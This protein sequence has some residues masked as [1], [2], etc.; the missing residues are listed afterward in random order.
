VCPPPLADHT[1]SSGEVKIQLRQVGAGQTQQEF[2]FL[3]PQSVR[4]PWLG[5][6]LVGSSDLQLKLRRMELG[7][8]ERQRQREHEQRQRDHE[9]EH[10]QIREQRQHEYEMRKVELESS[11]LTSSD[12]ASSQPPFRVDA[13]VMLIPKFT[14]YD[15]ETFLISF[16]KIAKLNAFAF[17][18][19]KYAA[20]LQAHLIQ[21]LY[22]NYSR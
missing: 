8:E 17:P 7:F 2:E 4:D 21:G 20:V 22:G 18:S 15:V 1:S 5:G 3:Q 12:S 10:E 14:E 13:A 16:E 11:P 19:D 6:H 9:R